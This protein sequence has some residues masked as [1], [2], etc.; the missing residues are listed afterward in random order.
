MPLPL[1]STLLEAAESV[2]SGW[3]Q[4]VS[5]GPKTWKLTAPLALL[6]PLSVATSWICEPTVAGAEACVE[7]LGC[8]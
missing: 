1:A 7:M 5:P 2:A 8:A 3:A 6:A 4:F